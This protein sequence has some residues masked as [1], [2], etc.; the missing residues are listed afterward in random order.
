MSDLPD[1]PQ[2]APVPRSTQRRR[3]DTAAA[4]QVP[5]RA[6]VERRA[7]PLGGQLWRHGRARPSH[8]AVLDRYKQRRRCLLRP[9]VRACAV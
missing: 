4:G 7:L 6:P 3:R 2:P 8:G 1:V 5:V 9:I